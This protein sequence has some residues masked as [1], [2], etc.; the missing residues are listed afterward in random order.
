MD[1]LVQVV[2]LGKGCLRNSATAGKGELGMRR[3]RALRACIA[4]FDALLERNDLEPEQRDDVERSRKRLKE[5]GRMKN[6][7]KAEMFDCVR[8]I[9]KELLD[10]L[11]RK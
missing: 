5:L 6:P 8:E 7:T 2:R 1:R 10:A 9:S 4:E 11:R 3:N